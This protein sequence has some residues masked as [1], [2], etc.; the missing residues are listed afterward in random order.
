M[1]K[2]VT[3]IIIILLCCIKMYAQTT[4]PPDFGIILA[5]T[6]V[7]AKQVVPPSPE[8]ASLGKYGNIPISLFTGTPNISI[9]LYEI[10]GSS[11]RLPVNMSYNA[12][13][14]SP[15]EVATWV[16]LGWSLNA[17]GVITRSVMGNPD[18]VQNYYRIPSPLVIPQQFSDPFNYATYMENL[19]KGNIEAQP[20]V[21]YYN[22]VGH[23]GKFLI[24]PDYSV[25]KKEK[26]NYKINPNI[27]SNAGSSISIIDDIG[28]R[29]DFTE[30]ELS[31][32]TPD[33]GSGFAP[34][35][36]N[37]VSTWYLTKITSAD[38]FEVI[39]LEYHD[40]PLLHTQF[41]NLSQ[42]ETDTYQQIQTFGQSNG[43]VTP[44]NGPIQGGSVSP[45]VKI[46]RKYLQKISHLKEG[47]LVGYIDF[48]STVDQ[49]QDLDH[50]SVSGYPGERLLNSV[51]VYIKNTSSSFALVKQYDLGYNYFSNN[52]NLS[53][54]Y[55]RLKLNTINEIPSNSSTNIP[56]PYEFT[57]DDDNQM[58]SA[59]A[60]IDHW[61]FYNG[62][63]G[64]I[65]LVPT[66][67]I[68][69]S[70]NL[71]VNSSN[72]NSSIL[73]SRYLINKI[74]YPTGGYTTFEYESNSSKEME[75]VGGARIK[76]VIDY[77]F[78]NK[79]AIEKNYKY[80]LDDGSTSGRAV[81]PSYISSSTY[82]SW[83]EQS[84]NGDI[85]YSACSL[86]IVSKM[87]ST[88]ISSSSNS[89]LGVFQGSHIGYSKVTETLNDVLNGEPL[90]KTTYDYYVQEG[91]WNIHDD[92]ISNGNL[93]SK[94]VFDNKGKL[95]EKLDNTYIYSQ[96]GTLAAVIPSVSTA[97]Q[98]NKNILV[99]QE[100]VGGG[101]V[102]NW[103][104]NASCAN[105]PPVQSQYIPTKYFVG[106][107]GYTT[108]N[109]Q[110]NQIVAT[111]YDKLS[112]SYI[113]TTKKFIYGNAVHNLPTTIEETTNNNEL[114]VTNKKYSLDF[115][116]PTSTSLDLNTQGIKL[117]QEKNIIGAEIE[118]VQ[119]RQNADGTNLIYIS[120]LLTNYNSLIPLPSSIYRLEILSPLTLFTFS[121]INSGV[122][123]YSNYYKPNRNFIYQSNGTLLEQS[124][125]DDIPT[126]YVWD[127]NY[128][129]PTASVDNAKIG[130]FAY[131]SF[132]TNETGSWTSIPNMAINRVTTTAFTGKYAY[133][134]LPFNLIQKNGL[135]TI[136]QYIVSYWAKTGS[137]NV[138]TDV[139]GTALQ[140]TG[141]THNGW[142]YYQHLLPVNT[143]NVT[144]TTLANNIIDEL[145]LY[146][147]DAYMT[148]MAYE[149]GVG[150]ISQNSPQNLVAY[151]EYD[152]LNR[153]I[154]LKDENGNIVKNYKYNYG[155]GAA[156]PPSA[157]TLFYSAAKQGSY[158]R[159]GCPIGTEPTTE[160][161][162]VD[163]GKYVSSVNQ[164]IA[165]AKATN[166]VLTNGQAFANATGKCL[167]WNVLKTQFFS[168]NDCA[169]SAG[170]SQCTNVGPIQLRGRITYTVVAH[171]YSSE[172]SQAD[173][174]QKALNDIATNGQ[175]YANTHC[176][177]NCSAVGQTVIN[178]VCE[179]GTRYNSG[180]NQ[181]AN[182]TWICSFYYVFSNGAVI[183]YTEVNATACQIQ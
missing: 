10:E 15:Q 46:K 53:P 86:S 42:N 147:K 103:F 30:T 87:Y 137:L 176:W 149:P 5:S 172:I 62:G 162:K 43:G 48:V 67:S 25:F 47:V 127:Y 74:T 115:L 21:F 167:Y 170:T 108:K 36:Y 84:G 41:N 133:N 73:G 58:P 77:S 98:D 157:Q 85:G 126:S 59:T 45:V 29:Y 128:R 12:S 114:L 51:K 136:R 101:T 143:V 52:N 160:I 99:K 124:K 9:P 110:L 120:G 177:C 66:S 104:Y 91:D 182:G 90:G 8:A 180:T 61:G 56:P 107:W 106:G 7:K 88:V 150:T 123:N 151:Y 175:N 181:Q 18:N 109:K 121:S 130:Q 60:G 183:N 146:P 135:P 100:L 134:I 11:I 39:N 1:I 168:K 116:I 44:L 69:Q 26:N 131:S 89:G 83:S 55:K 4:P 23:Q 118:S 129:Y 49:R 154:N 75:V 33:D 72:R 179:T 57:Y 79:K 112:D 102:Y 119:H 81:I 50:S 105:P 96:Q 165:D 92:D 3:K 94:S 156:L 169:A 28:V 122:L 64:Y 70:G 163:Y 80:V 54:S 34:R 63:Q 24:K 95:V 155:I 174:D 125:N 144:L 148:T 152:G 113:S 142:T 171:T 161:Y 178:G 40:V 97:P 71:V 38:G 153:L 13:G 2:K 132:E 141:A 164:T 17:G 76:K 117:L 145:R 138:S 158:T 111:K 140:T 27:S 6:A 68:N 82:N 37:Y 31:T 14:F 22:F 166:D 93:L 19:S 16:G 139:A 20:D 32:M 78:V 159:I 173:A 65:R 35:T